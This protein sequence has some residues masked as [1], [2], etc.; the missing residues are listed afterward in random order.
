M[1]K[2][3]AHL[4][5]DLSY[6]AVGPLVA[7]RAAVLQG[8]RT[9]CWQTSPRNTTNMSSSLCLAWRLGAHMIGGISTPTLRNLVMLTMIR[10]GSHH[11]QRH[12]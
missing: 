2:H 10:S 4:N 12:W 8:L 7:W 5:T 9:A 11:C 6:P 1:S 3:L